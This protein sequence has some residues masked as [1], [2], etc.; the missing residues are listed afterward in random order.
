MIN[1]DLIN[2]ITAQKS[3]GISRENIST[4]LIG[5]G[6]HADDVNEGLDKI[7]ATPA[8]QS[9]PMITKP[10]SDT[11]FD[12]SPSFNKP[13]SN[14]T[15][16]YT[17]PKP[18]ESNIPN[19]MPKVQGPAGAVPMGSIP[20]SQNPNP[21]VSS[22]NSF[23]PVQKP[24]QTPVA[25]VMSNG[26][27]PQGAV[28]SSYRKDYQNIETVSGGHKSHWGRFFFI[29]FLLILLAGGGV[30]FANMKGYINLPF[31]IPFLTP[32]PEQVLSKL[33][34]NIANL[35]TFHLD[36]KMS[37][38][39]SGE[40][41]TPAFEVD[42]EVVMD[43]ST[44][45][46]SGSFEMDIKTDYDLKD[47]N[48][49]KSRSQAELS[50]S[51]MDFF[52]IS[53]DTEMTI[54]GDIVYFKLPKDIVESF[55]D[56]ENGVEWVSVSK[57]DLDNKDLY[58]SLD[59]QE[60]DSQKLEEISKIF[61]DSEFIS[62]VEYVGMQKVNNESLRQYSIIVNKDNLRAVFNKLILAIDDPEL[63]NADK[64]AREMLDSL[65]DIK[66][67]V[68]VANGNMLRKFEVKTQMDYVSEGINAK[69]E[70]SVESTISKVNEVLDEIV[71]PNPVKSISDVLQESQRMSKDAEMKSIL[72]SLRA[73][74]ELFYDKNKNSYGVAN[75]KGSCATPVKGSL[76]YDMTS[77]ASL[78]EN[79]N[80]NASCYSTSK[81]YAISASMPSDPNI[82]WC[83]DSSG[84]MG[85]ITEPLTGTV[86]K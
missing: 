56:G 69:V 26:P 17:S 78:V 44:D 53:V 42:G 1:E 40:S 29:F 63:A 9:A 15:P 30:I 54:L 47:K 39:V 24:V 14:S 41:T 48:K 75:T 18:F 79:S 13:I 34:L 71:A 46:I 68:W 51:I 31:D 86:C 83:V 73:E 50:F 4:K 77:I 76:F 2:Y 59:S 60:Y 38:K 21:A 16:V 33:K 5:A 37:V 45:P 80:S 81:A 22:F 11:G 82:M 10:M 57:S 70:I 52:K 7:F 23:T 61:T 58:S 74:S 25:N 43:E 85:E 84:F 28:I 20:I 62:S 64:E 35:E 6:W 3:R 66:L 65:N 32:S 49:Q 72:Y 8:V 19:L 27:L 67:D 12:S 36:T 55:F